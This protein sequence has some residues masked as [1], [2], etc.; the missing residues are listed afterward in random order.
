[1]DFTTILKEC[2]FRF[3]RSSG[4]GG[5]HVNKVSTR[6]ELVFNILQSEVLTIEEK[7]RLERKLEHRLTKEGALLIA[8]QASRSQLK[9][10]Q[11][12][13]QKLREVLENALK[14]EKKRKPVKVLTAD[15]KKRLQYKKKQSDKKSLRKKIQL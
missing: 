6:V 12:A 2:Q 4:S 10:K 8:S 7:K 5:Q 1:M 15:P 14:R 3:S 9:N 11:K 13:I